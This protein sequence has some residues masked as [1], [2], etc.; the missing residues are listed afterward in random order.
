MH[1]NKQAGLVLSGGGARSAYQVGVLKG[2]I[3]IA[4]DMNISNPF[5]ILTG[6]SAGGM[7]AAYLAAHLDD[8]PAAVLGL[9]KLW[10]GLTSDK[11]FKVDPVSVLKSSFRLL[12]E[13]STADLSGGKKTR[14]LLDTTPLRTLIEKEYKGSAIEQSI[15][16]GK[17]RG[18]A[19]KALS[20]STGVSTTFFQ[21]AEDVKPW[22]HELRKGKRTR[23]TIDHIMASAALP[24]LFPPIKLGSQ[25]YGDGSLR[26][27]TP[28]SPAIK[29]GAEKLMVVSVRSNSQ[30]EKPKDINPSPARILG[31]LLNT[32]LLDAVEMDYERLV[33]IND[34]LKTLP[35]TAKTHLK[36]VEVS[37]LSPSKDIGE[38]ALEE[39]HKMPRTIRYMLRG[40]GSTTESADLISY[41]VFEPSFMK[42]VIELGYH[43]TLSKQAEVR[44]FFS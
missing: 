40:L 29:M 11:V 36:P 23:I 37:M 1:Q 7:N 10:G 27:S 34:I 20:Y 33:S 8:L 6:T 26:N 14:A 39:F 4:S 3:E 22:E 15:K 5:P 38:I 16:S 43:D 21:G 13:L 30:W 18:L 35:P 9:E 24:I 25:F 42:R 41:L 28:L 31:V 19:V 44:A 12:I 32:L 2:L 17:L